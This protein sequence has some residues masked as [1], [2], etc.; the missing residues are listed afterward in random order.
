[1]TGL[2]GGFKARMEKSFGTSLDH[3]RVTKSSSFPAKV[4]A[5]ATTRGSQIDIAPGHYRPQ[6]P[7]GQK[8]LGH[9]AW[10]T[11]QQASGRV[12]PT[13]Q[14]KTGYFVNDDSALEQ[15]ADRAGEAVAR[16]QNLRNRHEIGPYP[17]KGVIQRVT[18]EVP[19][20][21]T[22]AKMD[23]PTLQP[24]DKVKAFLHVKYDKGYNYLSGFGMKE[25]N[26]KQIWN[27][28]I[29]WKR[30]N[31]YEEGRS[32]IGHPLGPDHVLGSVPQDNFSFARRD[33][34]KL[35]TEESYV[36]GHL[37]SENLGGPGD[38]HN[39]TAIPQTANSQHEK[40]IEKPVKQLVNGNKKFIHYH[41]EVEY[42]NISLAK[43]NPKYKSILNSNKH[44]LRDRPNKKSWNEQSS[45]NSS[46]I[47]QNTQIE[48]AKRLICEW[49][50]FDYEGKPQ[51]KTKKVINIDPPSRS[52]KVN[53]R[54]NDNFHIPNGSQNKSA[55]AE[56][57]DGFHPLWDDKYAKVK[58]YKVTTDNEGNPLFP[59]AKNNP[60]VN[61]KKVRTTWKISTQNNQE[62]F[63]ALLDAKEIE[64]RLDKRVEQ[65]LNQKIDGL[66]ELV[67]YI[68]NR[69]EFKANKP[70]RFSVHK[71]QL[72]DIL[73]TCKILVKD[74]NKA[75]KKLEK[76]PE[77]KEEQGVW[78]DIIQSCKLEIEKMT[79]SYFFEQNTTFRFGVEIRKMVNLANREYHKKIDEY[80]AKERLKKKKLKEQKQKDIKMIDK[81]SINNNQESK[82][83][84]NSEA[85]E[86]LNSIKKSP[87][88]LYKLKHNSK[89]QGVSTIKKD[90]KHINRFDYR[91]SN[92]NNHV[93]NNYYEN[94]RMRDKQNLSPRLWSQGWSDGNN[95]HRR[96]K[97]KSN[98]SEY[99]R[100]Y[101][102][103]MYQK[104]FSLGEMWAFRGKDY[105]SFIFKDSDTMDLKRGFSDAYSISM[106]KISMKEEYSQNRSRRYSTGSINYNNREYSRSRSRSRNRSKK[107]KRTSNYK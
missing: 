88:E 42:Q 98:N 62:S 104:G 38:K 75:L 78:T 21:E 46:N 60:N 41:V 59:Y 9:E 13:L 92:N 17:L 107:K 51:K 74:K 8:L 63:E 97:Y 3:I 57:I 6:T 54:V 86:I 79:K 99:N 96:D 30:P 58:S 19:K 84:K 81:T 80:R 12:K 64:S 47:N 70:S 26:S 25:K 48:Y 16:G 10:H 1:A 105:Y 24:N 65:Y 95:R 93:K 27:T 7:Q 20:D 56:K 72:E 11:V 71:K 43:I 91:R 39:L 2:P 102:K 66:A 90:T 52:K 28:Q 15:E 100:G 50:V 35:L 18:F 53:A 101:E 55:I 44:D 61:A 37:L 31:N 67:N 89:N 36:C 77:I 69:F 22:L 106:K 34:L 94:R 85:M 73:N 82:L 103:G 76:K 68:Y 87:S 23:L 49:F 33:V 45:V 29:K 32:V 5:I 14:M 40:Q 4:G 83:S